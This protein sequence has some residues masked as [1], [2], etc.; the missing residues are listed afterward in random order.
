[1]VQ[2]SLYT[3][4]VDLAVTIL[5]W[6]YFGGDVFSSSALGIWNYFHVI[7]GGMMFVQNMVGLV[8]IGTDYD[9]WVEFKGEDQVEASGGRNRENI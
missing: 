1:M 2:A 4:N 9:G 8:V 7:L 5:A 6:A 3:I